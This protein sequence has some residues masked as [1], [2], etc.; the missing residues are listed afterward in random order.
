MEHSLSAEKSQHADSVATLRQQLKEQ[1]KLAYQAESL[2]VPTQKRS[3]NFS[4]KHL[5]VY[6]AGFADAL[7]QRH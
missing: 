6:N 2:Q 3:R 7:R 5:I 1:D 4:I